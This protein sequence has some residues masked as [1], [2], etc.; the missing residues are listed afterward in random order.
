MIAFHLFFV[1]AS[2][3]YASSAEKLPTRTFDLRVPSA[4]PT[5]SDTYV[6]TG[7]KVDPNVT[8]YLVGFEPLTKTNVAHHMLLY[9]CKTPGSV[10]PLFNCGAMTA[11]QDGKNV[12]ALLN[13]VSFRIK[14]YICVLV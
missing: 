10:E 3:H 7:I 1:F 8:Y 14:V 9:G 6:C 11:R 4:R 5:K 12:K 13:F 2:V